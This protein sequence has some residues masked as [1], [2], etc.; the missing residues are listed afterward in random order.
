KPRRAFV[1]FN[2]IPI[3]PKEG[4][5]GGG[6]STPQKV[7]SRLVCRPCVGAA[8]T[9]NSEWEWWSKGSD[10]IKEYLQ[11]SITPLL[12]LLHVH[13]NRKSISLGF[14]A[15]AFILPDQTPG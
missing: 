7:I 10:G 2:L 15:S 11:H 8:N 6:Y 12:L 5:A 4:R 13:F 9:D 1:R 14:L 3:P